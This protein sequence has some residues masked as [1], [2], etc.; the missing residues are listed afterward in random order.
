LRNTH[1]LARAV[2]GVVLVLVLAGTLAFMAGCL[3]YGSPEALYD[4]ARAEVSALKPHPLLVPTPFTQAAPAAVA[5]SAAQ[6]TATPRAAAPRA[7]RALQ[8]L[9]LPVVLGSSPTP[10]VSNPTNAPVTV[11]VAA[12][13]TPTVS[14]A[15]SATVAYQ[16]AAARASLTGVTHM[17]QTWNNCGPATLSM[18][19]SYFGS[20]LTQADVAAVLRPDRDDK[21]VNPA[22]MADFARKQGYRATVRVNGDADKLRLLLSNGFPVLVETWL[23]PKPNDGMGHYRL[24]TGYDDAARQWTVYDAY[25]S[26]G[27]E[28]NKPYGGIRSS[29]DELDSLWA[30]FDRVYIVIYKPEQEPL[31]R[32]ILGADAD[33]PAMWQRALDRHTAEVTAKPADAFTRFDQGTDLVAL[34]RYA[35][36]AAAYDQARVTGLPWRMLWYQFG[37]FQA[38]YETGRYDE[39]VALADATLKTADNIEELYYWKGLALKAKGDAAG[40]RAAW[41]R[42]AQLNPHYAD[43]TAALAKLGS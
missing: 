37:P 4:R 6:T 24:L 12:T 39:V 20:T 21:N 31:V 29:Y 30:V 41:E 42:A 28:P 8:Q 25:V 22:E 13:T 14:G 11:T 1:R 43:A 32:A 15:V 34:G 38:Y 9:S 7:T 27:V 2:S 3:H 17:W 16:P 33:D 18:N 10:T 26:T 35:E 40:A 5:A 19:L 23:E 36:A